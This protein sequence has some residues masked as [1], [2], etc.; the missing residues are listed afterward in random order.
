MFSFGH[1]PDVHLPRPIEEKLE[2]VKFG[3]ENQA[4]MTNTIVWKL[5]FGLGVAAGM[6]VS[7]K[8]NPVKKAYR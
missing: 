5:F 7:G 2:I 3:G 8:G 6:I 1:D 4:T